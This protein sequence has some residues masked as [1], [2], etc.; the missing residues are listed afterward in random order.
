MV[1]ENMAFEDAT[2]T[3][4]ANIAELP[5]DNFMKKLSQEQHE[6]FIKEEQE[7]KEFLE[8]NKDFENYDESTKDGL[9]EKVID[10]YNVYTKNIKT[11]KAVVN[12]T[13]LEIKTIVKMLTQSVKYDSTS[14]YYGLHL[15]KHMINEFPNV[16]ND[17]EKHDIE[18]T[19]SHAVTLHH[20]LSTVFVTGLSKDSIAFANII[21]E[22]GEVIRVY[23]HY[24]ELSKTLN[25]TMGAWNLGLSADTGN[26]IEK[27][28]AQTMLD[29]EVNK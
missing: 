5:K 28:V 26:Q 8:A 16:K 10:M 20:L 23:E 29:E 21:F 2:V 6:L 27:L 14:I 15:K 25:K 22:L 4:L 12:F 9:Y 18:V 3:K 11:A 19:F 17:G 7:I 13:G 1:I 24:D